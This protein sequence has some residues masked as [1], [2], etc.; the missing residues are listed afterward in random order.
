VT[1][2]Y[3][4][5]AAHKTLGQSARPSAPAH[6]RVTTPTPKSAS[7]GTR[8][9][10]AV[11]ALAAGIVAAAVSFAVLTLGVRG[12]RHSPPCISARA[13]E[14]YLAEGRRNQRWQCLGHHFAFAQRDDIFDSYRENPCVG[15]LCSTSAHFSQETFSIRPRTTSSGS[16]A[17]QSAP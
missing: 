5:W 12:A 2:T 13:I 17:R 15:K 3:S 7:A 11:V 10:L 8:V 6:H 9:D 4:P 14:S 16:L 1:T